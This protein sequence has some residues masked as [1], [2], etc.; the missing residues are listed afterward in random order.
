MKNYIIVFLILVPFFNFAQVGIGTVTPDVSSILDVNS[1]NKGLLIPRVNLSNITDGLSPIN[2]PQVGLLVFNTNASVIGGL[3]EGFYY[4]NNSRWN[5]L[6]ISDNNS[7]FWTKTGSFLHPTTVSDLV[8]IG[9][10]NPTHRLTVNGTT[11]TNGFIMPTGA[12]EG[13]VLTSSFN[14]TATWREPTISNILVTMSNVGV[15]VPFSQTSGFIQTNTVLVLPPGKYAVNINMLMGN[16]TNTKSPPNSSFW[17]RSTFSDSGGVNPAPSPN[18]I[19]S[20]YASGN[21]P[22]DSFFSILTGTIIINNNTGANK[23]YYYVAGRALTFNT[24]DTIKDIG[25]NAVNEN[26]IIAYRIK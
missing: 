9:T 11:N 23:T 1:N 6:I 8:G 2:S 19:G 20:F 17:L 21:L 16:T 10:N 13:H 18:I 5:K 22:G 24:S 25:S 26:N 7:D 14:G 12:I 3:G 15:D 4:W